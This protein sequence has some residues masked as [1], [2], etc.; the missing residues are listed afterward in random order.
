MIKADAFI[1]IETSITDR[2]N[3]SL[4]KVTTALYREIDTLI[5]DGDFNA[6]QRLVNGLDLSPVIEENLDYLKYITNVA[7][8]FGASRV[9]PKPGTSVV[10]LGYEKEASEKALRGFTNLIVRRGEYHLKTTA[11]Q[12]I[13]Q[14]RDELVVV[15]KYN[16]YHDDLGRFT[17]REGAANGNGQSNSTTSGA[18]GVSPGED[19]GGDSGR[20][21]RNLSR[22]YG[23]GARSHG[24]LNGES[25]EFT[26]YPPTQTM[27]DACTARGIDSPTYIE[28]HGEN[29]AK[30]FRDAMERAKQANTSGASVYMYSEDEY[31]AMR[32]FLTDGGTGGIAV[33]ADGDIVSVFNTPGTTKGMVFSALQLAVGN[34]GRKLDCFDTV[35]PKL[36]A[37][38][39]FTAQS[40]LKWDDTQ[41]PP[42]WNKS[43]YKAFNNGE[44]DVV[45]M[46]YD[47]K[48]PANTP[49]TSNEGKLVDSYD[50]AVTLQ[51]SKVVK[52][53]YVEKAAR[54]RI[55]K[56][57]ASF[58]DDS[59]KAFF[60][61]ASS[62]HTSRVS[63]YGFTAEAHALGLEEYQINEQLDNR[64][65]PVCAQMHGKKF[66]V[67]DAR[68]LLDSVILIDD[69]EQ[70]KDLHP[71]PK[72]DKASVAE[73][74]KMTTDELVSNRWHVPPF[75]P[76][77][78]GLLA[79]VGKVPSAEQV[80]TGTADSAYVATKEDFKALGSSFN[81]A[82]VDMWNQHSRISPLEVA[83]RLQGTT[84]D[85]LLGRL[86]KSKKPDSSGILGMSASK[87]ISLRMETAG[88][89]S[90]MPFYQN[91]QIKP[92]TKSLYINAVELHEKDQG[93]SI[94]KKY[95]RELISVARDMGL[96]SVTL[97]AGLS[98]GGYAWAK[99]GFVP[100]AVSW[101]E[102]V[103]DIG[104]RIA[105]ENLLDGLS[106]KTVSLIKKLL[107]ST[108]PTDI[109]LLSDLVE[110]TKSGMPVGKALLLGTT[111][112]GGLNLDDQ[113][114]MARF[115]AYLGK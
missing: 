44:P 65:C 30:V 80:V 73:L 68:T 13:A 35:L 97:T 109:F 57:F 3:K 51:Q 16:P 10:G 104:A 8:L 19:S 1:A 29:A 46:T 56:P 33:K 50:D 6:A 85:E 53:E 101:S 86:L 92:A 113:F 94:V 45:F 58:M 87:N 28:L 112:S 25:V 17:T 7:M 52:S 96:P 39:G 82:G 102:L 36:Y 91:I 108:D 62:L 15:H 12:L 2:L 41:A 71:W 107:K 90:T 34:G 103:K 63:A 105:K 81:Q 59:G 84:T 95:M 18:G 9:T 54:P 55:L 4:K 98:V 26:P 115:L 74:S 77:C 27:R 64:T 67:S 61:L 48:R 40:R 5:Q 66:R 69:P 75:H 49:Y 79:R 76:G 42:D 99:Y 111:W 24:V 114:A 89:G 31:K 60:N 83:A 37:N 110:K 70:I 11:L 106:E 93:A 23:R 14:A 32:L 100:T 38:A 43:Y 78:R 88:F 22:N 20:D 21:A 47:P 72:Q